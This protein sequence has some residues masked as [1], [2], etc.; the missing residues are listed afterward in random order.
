MVDVPCVPP[1]TGT[2][3]RLVSGTELERP[4]FK[5]IYIFRLRRQLLEV[6]KGSNV[7][8]GRTEGRE[9]GRETG[10]ERKCKIKKK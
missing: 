10:K 7:T 1:T 2:S 4:R 3:T 8:Y 5:G 6:Q 9:G